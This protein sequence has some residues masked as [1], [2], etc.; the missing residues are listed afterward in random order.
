MRERSSL[1]VCATVEARCSVRAEC[2]SR[3]ESHAR[4]V[5]LAR[6]CNG[7]GQVYMQATHKIG[8]PA[9]VG[10]EASTRPRSYVLTYASQN[11]QVVL[12]HMQDTAMQDVLVLGCEE[13][14]DSGLIVSSVAPGQRRTWRVLEPRDASRCT[15]IL[16]LP[17]SRN[18]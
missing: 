11:V 6:V 4:E 14:Y 3:A 8:L 9:C 15:C 1:L 2:V 10:E 13:R 16:L 17:A 5:E 12:G 18:V 7:R